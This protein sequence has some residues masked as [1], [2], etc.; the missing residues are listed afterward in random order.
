MNF[1]LLDYLLPTYYILTT[2]E[3]SSNLSRYDGVKFGYRAENPG[4]L[5]DMYKLSR[6]EG[7]GKDVQR[8]IMLGTFVLSAS[9][10]D[11]FYTKAQR[12][13]RLIKEETEKILDSYDFIVLPTTPTT[14]FEIGAINDPIDMFLADLYTVQAN[15]SG[16]P[17]ISIPVGVDQDELP[18]GMQIMSAH[19][20]EE[21]LLAFSH[22]VLSNYN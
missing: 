13:R 16:I 19:F 9:Y 14:A 7:F 17:A 21:K 5:E 10:Y 22:R 11:A 4:S 20:S 8:R 12:V 18:I 6:S 1:G 2:A 3:A 15:V